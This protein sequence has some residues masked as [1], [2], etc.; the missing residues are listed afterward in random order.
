MKKLLIFL[1]IF[2]TSS[3]SAGVLNQHTTPAERVRGARWA[4]HFQS[5]A[6]V[7]DVGGTVT[8]SPVF[9]IENG[10]T[11]DG[12]NDYLTYIL[13]GREFFSDPISFVIE[14]TPDF[15]DDGVDHFLFAADDRTIKFRTGGR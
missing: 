14:A 6:E 2:L 1:L 11:L 3:V 15:A 9:S 4:D 12:T 5:Q 7:I 13:T 8:G 10:V